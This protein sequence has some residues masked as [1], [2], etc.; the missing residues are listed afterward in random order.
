MLFFM[1]WVFYG[2]I[3]RRDEQPELKTELTPKTS[4]FIQMKNG[5]ATFLVPI[6]FI[7]AVYSLI[8]WAY[9]NF[10]VASQSLDKVANINNIFFDRFFL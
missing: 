3:P 4:Q 2:L 9:E 5:L 6:F 10:L 7:V 1:I 8:Q